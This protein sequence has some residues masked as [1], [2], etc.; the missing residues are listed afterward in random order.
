MH[1]HV[2]FFPYL[3]NSDFTPISVQFRCLLIPLQDAIVLVK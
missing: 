2:D 3:E 1:M